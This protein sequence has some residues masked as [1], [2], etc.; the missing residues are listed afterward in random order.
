MI[1]TFHPLHLTTDALEF[2]DKKYP[3]SW[4]D[5]AKDSFNEINTP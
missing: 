5:D 4:T 1:D 3:M 2:F